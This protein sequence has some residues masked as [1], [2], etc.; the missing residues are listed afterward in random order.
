MGQPK[1]PA[2]PNLN[3]AYKQGI[4]TY[5]QYNPQLLQ[6]EQ[7]ARATYDPQ[8]V[9]SQI[10]LQNQF[11]PTV[12]NQQLD[13]LKQLDPQGTALRQQMGQD[14][15]EDLANKYQIDPEL[16][17]QMTSQIR[18][19]QEARGNTLGN[20]AVSAEGIMKGQL[21]QQLYQQR[22]TNAGSFLSEPTPEQQ[23][24][25]VSPVSPDRSSQYVNPNAGAQGQQGALNNYGNV[26]AQY[27]LSGGS[28]NPWASAGVGAASGALAGSSFGPYGAAA[29]GIIGGVGGYFS[30]ARMK[31]DI[32]THGLTKEGYPLKS[33][34][35]KGQ[36][37]RFLGVIAQ[38]VQKIKPE[39]VRNINGRLSV[40]YSMIEAPFFEI[41]A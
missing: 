29:G 24:A 16:E 1:A 32:R 17:K 33:F 18:G 2:A 6:A 41:A 9:Q 40:D 13:A 23:L 14:V 12:Y 5:L 26:L 11:G 35:Y 28:R 4:K 15:S 3:K 22:L 38:D 37:K 30:D 21:A 36:T 19:A 7:S 20:D 10:D 25:L 27:Q 39:A 31:T 34:R 8:R